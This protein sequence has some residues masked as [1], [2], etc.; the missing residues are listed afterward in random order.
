MSIIFFCLSQA[1]A[2]FTPSIIVIFSA[3]KIKKIIDRVGVI[4]IGAS[5]NFFYKNIWS[6]VEHLLEY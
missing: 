6:I 4:K 5:I 2:I 3:S 1:N